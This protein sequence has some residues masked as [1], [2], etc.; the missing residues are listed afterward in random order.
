MSTRIT[1]ACA[2]LLFGLVSSASGQSV[3]LQFEN[4]RVNL[5]AQ[6][7]PLRTILV[8]WQRVGGTRIVNAE[9]V[10][11]A[12]VTLELN[13]VTERQALEILLRSVAGYVVTQRDAESRGASSF[14]G[15]VILATSSAP[16]TQAPVTFSNPTPRA[17]D[18]SRDDNDADARVAVPVRPPG[19]PFSVTS[20][21]P[22]T[23]APVVI[24]PGIV[25][26]G[27]DVAI[28]V[29]AP[30][31]QPQRPATTLQTLPGTSRPGEITPP[32]PPQQQPNQR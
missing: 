14:G 19:S 5:N 9:R 20:G 25:P 15:I 28:P 1:L 3:S 11:G 2:A 12:P 29:Q 22:T 23:A 6:N 8:E 27:Q 26:N 21:T 24:R 13:G 7:A 16:R 31:Q 32:P 4:G 18:D 30:V 10:G 17:F